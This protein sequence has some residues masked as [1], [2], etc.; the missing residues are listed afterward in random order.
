M[1]LSRIM[2][3]VAALVVAG[4]ST[5]QTHRAVALKDQGTWSTWSGSLVAIKLTDGR[6]ATARVGNLNVQR[7]D[8]LLVVYKA[9]VPTAE[10]RW[11][12]Q[13]VY[14]SEATP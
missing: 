8:S 9:G 14:Y 4:C 13:T 12:V 3:I 5:P 2:L 1:K 6:Y 11:H 10:K 7:G